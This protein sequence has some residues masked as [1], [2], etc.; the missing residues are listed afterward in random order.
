VGDGDGIIRKLPVVEHFH[1]CVSAFPNIGQCSFRWRICS[2]LFNCIKMYR[3][4]LCCVSFFSER[5][6]FHCICSE[7]RSKCGQVRKCVTW[8]LLSS[9]FNQN[10]NMLTGVSVLPKISSYFMRTERDEQ[11]GRNYKINFCHFSLLKRHRLQ[12]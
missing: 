3:S 1:A 5:F 11:T 9:D 10:W 6:S 12:S 2:D 4:A 7:S 8:P